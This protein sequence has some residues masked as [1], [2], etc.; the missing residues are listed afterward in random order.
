MLLTLTIVISLLGLN[1]FIFHSVLV[2]RQA[3]NVVDALV[4]GEGHQVGHG[5]GVAEKRPLTHLIDVEQFDQVQ[6]LCHSLFFLDPLDAQILSIG[7]VDKDD[8]AGE[9][10]A[11]DRSQ[12][13]VGEAAAQATAIVLTEEVDGGRGDHHGLSLPS[14]VSGHFI[15]LGGEYNWFALIEELFL[16]SLTHSDG[17]TIIC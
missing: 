3:L 7:A 17:L 8:L 10:G 15:D 12:V 2:L 14:V 5:H 6:E 16:H 13:W 11:N 4:G 9:T 1:L